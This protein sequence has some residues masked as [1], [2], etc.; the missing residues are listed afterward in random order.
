MFHDFLSC[1][2]NFKVSPEASILKVRNL[3]HVWA[4]QKSLRCSQ[5]T[6]LSSYL[7]IDYVTYLSIYFPLLSTN[8]MLFCHDKLLLRKFIWD[9]W[10]LMDDVTSSNPEN[11]N[12]TY[13]SCYI[14]QLYVYRFWMLLC[15]TGLYRIYCMLKAML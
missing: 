3:K 13:S 4:S 5:R 7:L 15:F 2:Y 1:L 9:A 14:V 11:N 10:S 12:V 8:S 6:A